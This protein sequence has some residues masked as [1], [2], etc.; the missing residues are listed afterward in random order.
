MTLPSNSSMEIFPSNVIGHYHVKLERP[1]RLEGRWVAGLVELHFPYS[2][3]NVNDGKISVQRISRGVET[4][5]DIKKGRYHTITQLL[6][7][8]R[9]GLAERE[10]DSQIKFSR[11]AVENLCTIEITSRDVELRLSANLANM[12]GFGN[13]TL[14]FGETR[15]KLHCDIEEGFNSLYV[16]S[17]L[18]EPQIIG[19]TKAP[20]LR[21]VNVSN[22]AKNWGN[23][24]VKGFQHIQYLP[25]I[26]SGTDTIEM[27][28]R[29]DDGG[30]IS[31]QNGKCCAVVHLKR[32]E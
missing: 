24:L 30:E 3:N 29:R 4:I 10:L 26:A 9:F 31:F 11:D 23:S 1:L 14:T 2:W 19:D 13:E 7:A 25:V 16:Y 15:G 18:V 32:T 6:E 20:L 5:V 12:L 28:I 22:S 8:I 21:V 27:L 17:N